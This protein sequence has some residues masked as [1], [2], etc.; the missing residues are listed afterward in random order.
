MLRDA[1]NRPIPPIKGGE[2]H[3]SKHTILEK[4]KRRGTSP[5]RAT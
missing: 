5:F 1:G 4:K 2:E 3:P